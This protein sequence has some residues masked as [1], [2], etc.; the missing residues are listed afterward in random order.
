MKIHY[1]SIAQNDGLPGLRVPRKLVSPEPLPSTQ[2]SQQMNVINFSLLLNPHSL[3]HL[4]DQYSY[5]HV[6][7]CLQKQVKLN[8]RKY[9]QLLPVSLHVDIFCVRQVI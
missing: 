7:P 3:S 8:Q 1:R 9:L 6:P 4:P 5:K 2:Y